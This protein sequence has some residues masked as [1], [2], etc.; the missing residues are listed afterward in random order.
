MRLFAILSTVNNTFFLKADSTSF[1]GKFSVAK[2]K[3]E[4]IIDPLNAI[5]MDSY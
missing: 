2:W 5:A 4:W 1:K 3:I